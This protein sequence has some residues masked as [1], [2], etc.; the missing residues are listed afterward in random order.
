[1]QPEPF[2]LEIPECPAQDVA[3]L[4]RELG[5]S[6]ALAQVL[7]RRGVR[8]PGAARAFLDASEQHAPGAFAGMRAAVELVAR[9]L[10]AGSRV[11]VHG[12]Y[13]VDGICSTAVLVRAL[14]ALGADVDHF[15]PDRT[16]D[17]YGL[18][19]ATV[20]RL[21]ARGTKLLITVD[22]A[23]TAVAEVA[24]ARALEMD[25]LVT[26]HHTPRADGAL[27]QAPIVHPSLSSYPC[28]ELCATAVAY[29]LACALHEAR[30]G[31][32]SAP[33]D[34]LDLVALATIADVVPLLGENRTLARQGLRALA[35]THKP[36]LR[37]LMALANV[38]ASRVDER[39]VGFALGPRLNAAGR[40]Q[41]AD[42]G[43]ELILTEDAG[44]A[45][46]VAA[47]LDR[48]NH[49]RRAVERRIMFAAEEEISKL[50]PRRAYVLAQEGWHA[51]VIGIV[52]SRLAERHRRPVVLVALDGDGGRGSGR[53]IPGFD[54]HAGLAACAEHLSRYGGH[55]AAAGLEID[56]GRLEAFAAAFDEHAG[57]V[58]REE[59]TV[60]VERVDAVVGGPELSMA[61]A[62]ELAAMAP[63]GMGNPS[64]SLL[65][66]DARFGDRRP[67]GEGRHVRFTVESEGARARG[68]AFGSGARLPVGDGELAQA[69]FALEV[70]EWRGVS[71]PRL[72][73]RRARPAPGAPSQLEAP[74]GD[75]HA[76]AHAAQ[77][78]A[79]TGPQI[80]ARRAAAP[81]AQARAEPADERFEHEELVLFALE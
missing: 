57:S 27:P 35:R 81:P 78:I 55:R 40:M 15:L 34:D 65:V 8:D 50:P 75:S 4:A 68:V 52:A 16:S 67:M 69:T 71:E 32:A 63:F 59:D 47:E 1:M 28:R 21:A 73:L 26:D 22:C 43:L 10:D 2:R 5:V 37:A 25:V 36:G 42:A 48:A 12:D 11:T 6:A 79:R 3:L 30:T 31:D 53:S 45:Q 62:E 77:D 46:S 41:R 64:V 9:H 44:R 7:V 29:K 24:R 17:G 38:D 66:E 61:L 13:D 33:E 80:L 23:I 56:R 51:G 18:S 49:E 54:L 70:N 14:R 74:F 20:E 39:A 60:P 76:P 58:L 19:A 72:V